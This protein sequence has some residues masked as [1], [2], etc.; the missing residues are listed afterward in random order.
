MAR[1]SQDFPPEEGSEEVDTV[2]YMPWWA[3]RS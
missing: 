3:N 2:D 1:T